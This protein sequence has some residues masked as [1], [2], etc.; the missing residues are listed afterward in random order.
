[1][2]DCARRFW[3]IKWLVLIAVTIAFFFIPEGDDFVF[4]T[5]ESAGKGVLDTW[6]RVYQTF[7]FHTHTASLVIGMIGAIIFIVIQVI[8]LVDFAHT[9]AESWLVRP[10]LPPLPPSLPPSPSSQSPLSFSPPSTYIQFV[11]MHTPLF[12]H[13][14]LSAQLVEQLFYSQFCSL[15]PGLGRLKSLTTSGGT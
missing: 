13:R 9:W 5:S 7:A 15:P 2:F 6:K 4:S 12:K 8:L 14:R 10:S 1:M 11:S 3:C